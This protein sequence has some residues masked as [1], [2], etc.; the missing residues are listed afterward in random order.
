[1]FLIPNMEFYIFSVFD[2]VEIFID[3]NGYLTHESIF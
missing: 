3:T 2:T 1:M